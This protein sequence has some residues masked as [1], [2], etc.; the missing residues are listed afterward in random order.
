[1]DNVI[2]LGCN[3]AC[4][5]MRQSD[6]CPIDTVSQRVPKRPSCAKV[7]AAIHAIE[8]SLCNKSLRKTA[9]KHQKHPEH[10]LADLPPC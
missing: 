6:I 3:K 7:S 4:T 8:A 1:M 2:D 10:L 5:C 9:Q